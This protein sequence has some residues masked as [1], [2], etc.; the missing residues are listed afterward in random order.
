VPWVAI[1]ATGVGCAALVWWRASLV[2]SNIALIQFLRLTAVAL[3]ASAATC[4]EDGCEPLTVTTPYGRLRRRAL[5]V[6]MTCVV[7]VI[8]WLGVALVAAAIAIGPVADQPLPL[9]GLLVELVALV[10]CG[11]FVA[12]A[13]IVRLGWRGSAMRAAVGL[14]AAAVC[15]FGHPQLHEWLWAAPNLGPE[16]SAGRLRWTT[17]ACA[18][19]LATLALSLD[20][21]SRRVEPKS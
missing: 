4:L 5:A 17:I 10:A 9:A 6:A 8:I 11:W 3:A 16:W 20:P 2:D 1:G 7:V 13:V 15:T 12:A 18:A 21:A 14:V 19:V